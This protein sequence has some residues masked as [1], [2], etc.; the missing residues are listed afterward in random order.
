MTGLEK[1]DTRLY[2]KLIMKQ[3]QFINT[4]A[5]GDNWFY[6]N[7]GHA[8]VIG[9][10]TSLKKVSSTVDLKAPRPNETKFKDYGGKCMFACGRYAWKDRPAIFDADE[11]GNLLAVC[12]QCAYKKVSQLYISCSICG[13]KTFYVSGKEHFDVCGKTIHRI[14]GG[15]SLVCCPDCHDTLDLDRYK[16]KYAEKKISPDSKK[17]LKARASFDG[18]YNPEA[19]A[20]IGG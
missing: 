2:G 14:A 3:V 16:S 20:N 13:D 5:G 7:S 6:T 9:T 19:M 4:G 15:G 12:E 17:V 8:N 1:M 10:E 18:D 11:A